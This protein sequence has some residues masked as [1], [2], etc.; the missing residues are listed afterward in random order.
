MIH[1]NHKHHDSN[2]TLMIQMLK[3]YA[4]NNAIG[5]TTTGL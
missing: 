1:K 2:E 5:R 4:Q 3:N